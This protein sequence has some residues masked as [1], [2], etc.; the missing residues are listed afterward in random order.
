MRSRKPIRA[1]LFEMKIPECAFTAVVLSSLVAT[2]D[3]GE[4]GRSVSRTFER[5]GVR[6]RLVEYEAGFLAD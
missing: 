2:V 6:V 1:A 5:A 3:P 4:T